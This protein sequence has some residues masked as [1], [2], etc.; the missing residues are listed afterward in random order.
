VIEVALRGKRVKVEELK[1]LYL[2][3]PIAVENYEKNKK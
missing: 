2:Q 1:P 3:K